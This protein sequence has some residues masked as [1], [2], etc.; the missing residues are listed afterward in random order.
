M[1][2][3]KGQARFPTS[4]KKKGTKNKKTQSLIDKAEVL[5]VD[6]FEVLLLFAKNDWRS[7]G[8]HEPLI[9]PD[10]RVHA[11]KEA[12]K[13]LYS[14]R[15]A[16]DVTSGGESLGNSLIDILKSVANKKE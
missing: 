14:Q 13:Y 7:L 9:D 15:K 12:C 8:Y 4:G 1:P 6:P 3:V 16:I 10:T 11:A 5:G 2:F